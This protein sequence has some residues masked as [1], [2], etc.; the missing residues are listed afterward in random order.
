LLLC[1]L[2]VDKV[3]VWYSS[4]GYQA[5]CVGKEFI[6]ENLIYDDILTQRYYLLHYDCND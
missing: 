2:E 6:V 5:L 4:F 3:K 1:S